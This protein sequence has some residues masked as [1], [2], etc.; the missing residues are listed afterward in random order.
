MYPFRRGRSLT[1]CREKPYLGV[2]TRTAVSADTVQQGAVL[3][4]DGWIYI[5]THINKQINK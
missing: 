4:M 5:Y 3:A 1:D 2:L